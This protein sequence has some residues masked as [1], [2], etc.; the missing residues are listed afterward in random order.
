MEI[1][2]HIT[3]VGLAL[4]L[5]VA[6]VI[7]LGYVVKRLNHGGL[8]N[9]GD[10]KVVATTFLGPKERIVLVE[11]KGRQVLVGVNPQS[12]RTLT[13]F[14]GR[15]GSTDSGSDSFDRVLEAAS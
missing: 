13:E 9:A 6:L 1:G 8:R 3:Q 11:V 7:A 14:D 10:I 5:I 2:D 15:C 4:A 12:I